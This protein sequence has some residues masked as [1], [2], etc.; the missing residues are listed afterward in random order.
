MTYFQYSGNAS[1]D[2]EIVQQQSSKPAGFCQLEEMESE[3]E[4]DGDLVPVK[5]ER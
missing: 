5:K 1:S 4:I 3:T 2:E